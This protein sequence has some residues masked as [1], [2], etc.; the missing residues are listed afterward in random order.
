M[1]FVI[2][3]CCT[4]L[5]V[6]SYSTLFRLKSS[7]ELYSTGDYIINRHRICITKIAVS[8]NNKNIIVKVIFVV[9]NQKHAISTHT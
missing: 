3:K 2:F 1:N 4:L 6:I 8:T 5:C 7:F 9:Q